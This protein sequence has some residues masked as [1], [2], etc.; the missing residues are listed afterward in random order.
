MPKKKCRGQISESENESE[1]GK[2]DED[3]SD[4]N[5]NE[6]VMA[7]SSNKGTKHKSQM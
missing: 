2:D 4:D 6:D 1:D 7:D 5:L 3:L